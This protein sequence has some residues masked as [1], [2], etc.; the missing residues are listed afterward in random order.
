MACMAVAAQEGGAEK[1]LYN[2][3]WHRKAIK[4]AVDFHQLL[5]LLNVIMMMLTSLATLRW[6]KIDEWFDS[7]NQ[8]LLLWCHRWPNGQTL[9]DFYHEIRAKYPDHLLMAEAAHENRTKTC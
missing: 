4:E 7:G 6:K 8:R 9:D 1:E 5:K 2:Y 3:D